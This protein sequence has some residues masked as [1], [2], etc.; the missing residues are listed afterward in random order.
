[1]GSVGCS[2]F[3]FRRA[4]RSDRASHPLGAD[5]VYW[6]FRSLRPS[7]KKV[8]PVALR[9]VVRRPAR[10][11][12]TGPLDYRSFGT[13]WFG[14]A[15]ERQRYSRRQVPF[16]RYYDGP[17]RSL[18]IT[19]LG[20]LRPYPYVPLHLV[21]HFGPPGVSFFGRS[22]AGVFR[23]LRISPRL[24]LSCFAIGAIWAFSSCVFLK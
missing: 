1:M 24:A 19:D 7:L 12:P 14:T 6:I 9:G 8:R 5:C 23:C 3:L 13:P 16:V 4:S 15:C 10:F 17:R 18:K 22:V 20:A 2:A 21:G 11:C